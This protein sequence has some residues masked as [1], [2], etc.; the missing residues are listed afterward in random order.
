MKKF[1]IVFIVIS[2]VTCSS[3]A[4][5]VPS[6]YQ[7]V[8]TLQTTAKAVGI[9]N[10]PS[11]QAS[12]LAGK[13]G[14][15]VDPIKKRITIVGNGTVVT[16]VDFRGWEVFVA[17]SNVVIQ[18]NYFTQGPSFYS[19]QITRSAVNTLVEYNSF[20]GPRTSSQVSAAIFIAGANGTNLTDGAR[21]TIV[22]RNHVSG[23]GGDG[24]KV[25][26]SPTLIEENVILV[27]A[28]SVGA[29]GDQISIQ[30]TKGAWPSGDTVIVRKN[31]ISQV[32]TP[33]HWRWTSSARFGGTDTGKNGPNNSIR[34][35]VNT[36]DSVSV[37]KNIL[38]TQNILEH[39]AYI[40]SFTYQ[41]TFNRT[42]GIVMVDN[43]IG[44]NLKKK[45]AYPKSN[46]AQWSLNV[47]MFKYTSIAKP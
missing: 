27:N 20:V 23:Y 25:L 29:H 40:K 14:I 44:A 18:N 22:R 42:S 43:A 28:F 36:K 39:D 41:S 9:Q 4:Q 12:A 26:S 19:L 1:N 5:T 10:T 32:L 38:I 45:Y 17:G 13:A 6:W 15:T 11:I 24:I 8:A 47:D 46:I 30:N 34:V 7:T 33:D 35:V 3:Q 37:L 31:Y 21:D 2:L 16:G